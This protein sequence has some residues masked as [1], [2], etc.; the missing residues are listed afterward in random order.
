MRRKDRYSFA[1]NPNR[2]RPWHHGGAWT[3]PYA[4]DF[5]SPG[6]EADPYRLA[7][8][9]EACAYY[10]NV[11]DLLK[12]GGDNRIRIRNAASSALQRASDSDLRMV[13]R[14]VA[15]GAVPRPETK[16]NEPLL[17][18]ARLI[19]SDTLEVALSLGREPRAD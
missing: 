12:P 16:G 10:F 2:M 11:T 9:V 5:D 15:V 13:L 7:Q 17:Q 19:T 6:G 18:N 8:P 1:R 14:T 4:P 3:L